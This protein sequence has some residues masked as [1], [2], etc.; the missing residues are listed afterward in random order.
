MQ[1][2]HIPQLVTNND[3]AFYAWERKVFI[4][5]GI[6]R[7]SRHLGM[8]HP[9]A[10]WLPNK[11][12]HISEACG[13]SLSSLPPS[14]MAPSMVENFTMQLN[15]LHCRLSLSLPH[16]HRPIGTSHVCTYVTRLAFGAPG[17]SVGTSLGTPK[18]Q[19]SSLCV[20]G[21]FWIHGQ[22]WLLDRIGSWDLW[23]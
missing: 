16:T 14:C 12:G 13:P 7:L 6:F 11:A 19:L 10:R 1:S 18:K 8:P 15:N 4:G 23:R 9:G 5:E 2:E 20:C 3:D 21:H 17:T 22:V